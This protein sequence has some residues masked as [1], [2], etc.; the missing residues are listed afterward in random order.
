[1]YIGVTENRMNQGPQRLQEGDV[2][3]KARDA[4][5]AGGLLA[6]LVMLWHWVDLLWEAVR[7]PGSR[8]QAP[9]SRL[10]G[11]RERWGGVCA[12]LRDRES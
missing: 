12:V 7:A 3:G 2:A 4:Q 5:K 6:G 9:G 1:M 8:L 11:R 10:W